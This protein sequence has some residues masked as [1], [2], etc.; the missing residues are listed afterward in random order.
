MLIG[1][2]AR[3]GHASYIIHVAEH[4]EGMLQALLSIASLPSDCC[5][6]YRLGALV[7]E[8]EMPSDWAS[9]SPLSVTSCVQQQH[10][11][12]LVR[13]CLQSSLASER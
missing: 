13:P 8:A 9:A 11:H 1:M 10:R 6:A 3:L 4:A 7:G 12:Q 2:G 5:K